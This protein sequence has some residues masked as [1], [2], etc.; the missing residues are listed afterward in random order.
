MLLSIGGGPERQHFSSSLTRKVR[1]FGEVRVVFSVMMQGPCLFLTDRRRGAGQD[2]WEAW[3][4]DMSPAEPQQVSLCL[5]L[6]GVRFIF[7]PLRGIIA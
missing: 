1:G 2:A 5:S 7:E 4:P 6:L 3:I